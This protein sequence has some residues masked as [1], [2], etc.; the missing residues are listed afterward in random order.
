VIAYLRSLPAIENQVPA[1]ESDFPMNFIINTIPAKA[2]LSKMPQAADSIAYGKY[3]VTAA[4]CGECHTPFDKG[5]LRMEE[6]LSGGREFPLPSGTVISANLTP[7]KET[8]IGNWS[9]EMFMN[10]FRAYRDSATAHQK[11]DFMKDFNTIMPW[12]MYAGMT[13]QDLAAIYAY[14]QSVEP[15]KKSVVKFTPAKTANPTAGR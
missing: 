12:T 1:S 6:F 13:D 2:S 5:Q 3:V 15:I 11:V 8:G 14:L 10:K 4:S 7:D 9:R